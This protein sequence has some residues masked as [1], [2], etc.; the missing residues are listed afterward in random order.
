[1]SA[2]IDERDL[3]SMAVE[4][5]KEYADSETANPL[6]LA[7]ALVPQEQSVFPTIFGHSRILL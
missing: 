3:L 1:M 7:D 2:N 4:I 6:P 5:V